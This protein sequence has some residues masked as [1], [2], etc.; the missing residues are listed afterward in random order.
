[1]KT[2]IG[3]VISPQ[4]RTDLVPQAS[5]LLGQIDS[6]LMSELMY[7]LFPHV[8]RTLESL[9]QGWVTYQRVG[10]STDRVVAV[11]DAVIRL[12]GT[13]RA[14][15]Y[16]EYF[17]P[18]DSNKFPKAI[19]DYLE[20][21][22][23]PDSTVEQQLIQSEIGVG[24]LY[25]IGLDPKNLYLMLPTERDNE[26]FPMGF[27]CPVCNGFYLHSAGN[28]CPKCGDVELEPSTTRQAPFDYYLYL[29]EKSGLP[30]RFHCEELTGQ[31]DSPDRPRRQRRFQEIFRT[32]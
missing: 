25:N 26:G 18:G 28:L 27:R 21:V 13:R 32:K 15:R 2:I 24:G 6:S 9:G 29:S 7:A 23:I 10:N 14:H 17:A 22:N 1:M 16:A 8:A 12:L 31:T 3:K 30:F 11:T 4:E 19:R 5:R 20:N